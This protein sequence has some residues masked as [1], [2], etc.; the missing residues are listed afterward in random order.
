MRI[1]LEHTVSGTIESIYIASHSGDVD[2]TRR[3][4]PLVAGSGIRGDRNFGRSTV[5]HDEQITLIAAEEIERFRRET[6][7][8]HRLRAIR[9]ATS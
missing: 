5:E 4:A 9:A 2:A 1:T 7:L 3:G 8:A 6:G